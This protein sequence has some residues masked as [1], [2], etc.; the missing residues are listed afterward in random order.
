MSGRLKIN[1]FSDDL[2]IILVFLCPH[3]FSSILQKGFGKI[4]AY[5]LARFSRTI[6]WV[7]VLS[8]S[9]MLKN[10]N[11]FVFFLQRKASKWM[12]GLKR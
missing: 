11:E 5:I 4:G 1:Y 7:N 2:F 6:S 9:Y 10:I 12:V 8:Y 3:Y